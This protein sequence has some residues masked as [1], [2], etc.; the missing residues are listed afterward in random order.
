MHYAP[1]PNV[2][3]DTEV[4]EQDLRENNLIVVGGPIVNRVTELLNAKLPV[5]FEKEIHF[6]VKS[7]IT[8]KVYPSDEIGLI[9]KARNP[10][11]PDKY[12]L[13]VAGKRYPGTRAAILAFTNHF[14]E[15]VKGNL[16]DKNVFAKV[17]EGV[18]FDSDGV[19]DDAEIRE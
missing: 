7:H 14:S 8:G 5:R 11:N 2:K 19:V 13:V 15:I 1:K 17:V 10:F 6:A 16:F 18:D 3:L 4:R 12:V 9:V